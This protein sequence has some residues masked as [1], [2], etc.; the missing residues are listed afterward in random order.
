MKTLS[1]WIA[2]PLFLAAA[3]FAAAQAELVPAGGREGI[4]EYRL[5]PN[6]LRVLLI[7]D[8][9]QPKVTVN[10]TVFVG[11]VHEDYGET[12][13][14]HL[15]E[16]MLFK[17][18]PTYPDIYKAL[19]ERGASWNGSTWTDRTNYFET[20][21]ASDSNLEFGI[22]FEADRMVNSFVRQSDLDSE[23]TVVRNEF[24]M[25]ENSPVSVLMERMVS[26]S[27]LFH[28]YGH[29]TIGARSDLEE[30]PI[31]RLQSFYQ[32]Y[33]QPDNAL[34]IVAGRFDEAKAKQTIAQYFGAIPKPERE[35]PRLYTI[36][37]PQDGERMVNLRRVGE[38]G[39]VGLAYHV[40]AG[41]HPDFPALEVISQVLAAEPTGRL[42]KRL[43]E[44]KKAVNVSA[45]S[46]QM[47]DPASF[48]VLSEV[49]KD[50]S[51]QAVL[52]EAIAIVEG[53]EQEPVT[54]RELEQ[55]I[56]AIEKSRSL[57]FSNSQRLAIE[58]SEWAAMGDW[59]LFFVHGERLGE[60]SPE[61][62]TATAQ[63]YLRRNNRTAGMFIP[64]QAPER[65][66]IPQVENL[67]QQIAELRGGE[68]A[69]AAAEQVEA[70][71]TSPQNLEARVQRSTP[72]PGFQLATLPK[73]TRGDRVIAQLD[74]YVGNP[75]DLAGRMH[76]NE[77]VAAMLS[78]GTTEHTRE[79]LKTELDR[80]KASVRIFGGS[81][82]T[83]VRIET[84]RASLPETL[85]LVIE[86]LRQPSFDPEELELLRR[87]TLAALEEATKEPMALAP[88]RIRNHLFPPDHI[89]YTPTIAEQIEQAESITVEQL[90]QFH[91]DFYAPGA[92]YASIVGDFDAA[93]AGRLLADGL[94]GWEARRTSER[95]DP[96]YPQ[97]PKTIDE[98]INTPDK[99]NAMTV[100]ADLIRVDREDPD[101]SA[102]L[103]ANHILGG[104][105]LSSRLGDRLRQK[106]GLSYGAGSQVA[107]DP[108]TDVCT[109]FGY[110]ISAPQNVDGVQQGLFEELKRFH[111]QGVGEEELARAKESF[112]Q[113]LEV[114]L[115]NDAVLAGLLSRD[116][117]RGKTF[118]ELA[119]R[120]AE[121]RALAKP[122]VDAAIRRFFDPAS[123][124][125]VKA[126]DMSKV[127]AATP[128]PTSGP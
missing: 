38:V 110:A 96:T 116:L 32:R 49:R 36:E 90:R 3:G 101:Y 84:L 126:G 8:A 109:F 50:G 30:I 67:E 70:F 61:K 120:Q 42:Y 18:T 9:S 107:P 17:G 77:F 39:A 11:S 103:I 4:Q 95:I 25:G 121:I 44:T 113:E 123:I 20:L 56:N 76:V 72:L 92:A 21:P 127:A 47:R 53:L 87:E 102:L 115:A 125:I 26:T 28:G 19:N 5:E 75:A 64:T 71:D 93:E 124:S 91:A 37:P 1:T 34:L 60:L 119:Q 105:A 27:Y 31:T 14:A 66:G 48:M 46:F 81:N 69:G 89:N 122:E 16:H 12:G 108:R 106:D 104:E 82:Q 10:L 52:D 24:E 29:S 23:M 62:V 13:A 51:L 88:T 2:L 85:K 35:L 111:D 78:R 79:E 73:E 99:E 7:P 80:L 117:L 63:R 22:R 98:V 59:R 118:E 15:L 74:L 45:F 6:G 54:P 68:S 128:Q 114:S 58:M 112:L 57:L 97:E 33:Y 86:M 65:V 55:A 41:S 94:A 83:G 100:I 43:V 40:P